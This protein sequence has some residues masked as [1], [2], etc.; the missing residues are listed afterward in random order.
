[1]RVPA[2]VVRRLF[3]ILA[4]A[5]CSC[6]APETG[7]LRP[8][9]A[10]RISGEGGLTAARDLTVDRAGNVFIFDYGD[11]VIRKFDPDGVLQATFGGTGAEPGLFQHL[12]A[13]RVQGDRLFSLDAGALSIFDPSGGLL[14]HRPFEDTVT[15]DLPRLHADSS[16]VAEWIIEETAVQALTYRYPDGTERGRLASHALGTHFPGVQAN[17]L[18]F[19]K[20]TQ[21]PGYLYDFLGNGTVVWMSTEQLRVF[22]RHDGGDEVLFEAEATPVPYPADEIT[23]LEQQRAALAPPLFMNV[24]RH[25]RIA[26]HLVVDESGDVWVFVTSLERTGFLRLSSEGREVGFYDVDADFDVWATRVTSAN[27]RFYFMVATRGETLV[28]ESGAP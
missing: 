1:M 28:Y 25:Y 27:E 23:A 12:M 20:Q 24:P 8:E 11:Y 6:D 15:C 26:H 2:A 4:L 21:A 19:L 16:W 22:V 7:A 5:G 9:L 14:S 3:P 18:F 17:Q 13:I 10:F